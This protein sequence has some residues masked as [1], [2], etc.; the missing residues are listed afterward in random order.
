MFDSKTSAGATLKL[1]ILSC[2][3]QI[4]DNAK[5]LSNL[6][7]NIEYLH[8]MRVGVCNLYIV[9]QL[10]AKLFHDIA[11]DAKFIYFKDKIHQLETK[12]G[13][14]RNLDVFAYKILPLI[15]PKLP[16]N[17]VQH[18]IQ[19]DAQKLAEV[20]IK[21]LLSSTIF[22]RGMRICTNY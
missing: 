18:K 5:Q 12:L 16:S 13:F 11:Y 2:I 17:E 6:N 1:I 20:K 10:L 9:M 19:T 3:L 22:F 7:K 8:Q 14:A 15:L 4:E 21:P